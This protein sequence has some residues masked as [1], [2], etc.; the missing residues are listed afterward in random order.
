MRKKKILLTLTDNLLAL[1]KELYGRQ[2]F[3]DDDANDT[4]KFGIGQLERLYK[5][6]KGD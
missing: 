4:L 2:E 6:L 3:W 1:Y 5:K